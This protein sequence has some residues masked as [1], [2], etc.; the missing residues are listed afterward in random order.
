MDIKYLKSDELIKSTTRGIICITN[1]IKL[2]NDIIVSYS[3]NLNK[4]CYNEKIHLLDMLVNIKD[5]LESKLSK[6]LNEK[7]IKSYITSVLSNEWLLSIQPINLIDKESVDFKYSDF[8]NISLEYKNT[9]NKK[10]LSDFKKMQKNLINICKKIEPT[11]LYV[12]MDL[13]T[14]MKLDYLKYNNINESKLKLKSDMSVKFINY[15]HIINLIKK[16]LNLII[17][18][19]HSIIKLI[20][21]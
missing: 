14:K 21:K 5:I 4:I 6:L 16:E 13:C 12:I 2:S 11:Y 17:N 8:Y 10:L 9:N 15:V 18:E 3:D 1:G 7:F 20:N 19:C